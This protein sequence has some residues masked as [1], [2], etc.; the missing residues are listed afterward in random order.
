[1]ETTLR[2][3]S[4]AE[5][6]QELL[7][8]R[9][10]KRRRGILAGIFCGLVT[11]IAV[12]VLAGALWMPVFQIYGISMAPTF[13]KGDIVAAADCG[14]YAPGDVIAF[15]HN[16]SIQ[17]RRIIAG[18][19]S[20]VEIDSQGIVRVDGV[21]LRESYVESLS[22]GQS[23]VTYPYRV[24]DGCWFVLGDNR[25]ESIDSRSSILGCVHTERIVGKIIFRIW[26]LAEFG[27]P[28]N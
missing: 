13:Q 2:L 10:K 3:P 6:E 8:L 19:G 12:L 7:R 21:L 18:P 15:Y 5:L 11:L 23:D 28:E 20:T 24:P 16:N 26:P 27:I 25:A 14:S 9:G 22:L 17:V 4:S 1:M